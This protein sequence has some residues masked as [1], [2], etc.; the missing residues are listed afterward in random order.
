[1]KSST[2]KVIEAYKSPYP[3]SIIFDQGEDVE[4][5]EKYE[6]DPDWNDWYWCEAADGKKAWIPGQYLDIHGNGGRLNTEYDAKE[7]SL[8]PDEV[9]T[10]YK[11][12]N[13]FAIA[14]NSNGEV[15]WAP[16]RNMK[17]VS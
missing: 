6:E 11:I 13:G 12:V 5:G 8:Q 3:D 4:V 2:Y 7:L 10:V 17:I 1:M 16:L 9:V 14:E 15:A